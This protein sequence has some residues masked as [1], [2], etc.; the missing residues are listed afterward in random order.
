MAEKKDVKEW[1][2]MFYF[3]SDNPLAPEV[4]SQLKALKNAGYHQKVNVVAYFDPQSPGTPAH[5]FDVNAIDKRENSKPRIGFNPNDPFVRNL[6]LDKLWGED[7][8]G[9]DGT[10]I[11]DLIQ[12][13]ILKPGTANLPIA[14][15][16]PPPSAKRVA[17]AKPTTPSRTGKHADEAHADKG[18]KASL[19]EFLT[20][21]ASTYPAEHYML[22]ILGHGLVVG[23]DVFLFDEH[24]ARQSV[25]LRELGGVLTG[26]KK[27]IQ[28]HVAGAEFELV[29]FHSCSMSS[30]EVAY[31][32]KDTAKYMLASQ[33]PAFVSSW[34]YTQ[35]LIR[36]FN[37]VKKR[38]A[39]TEKQVE[40][41]VTKIFD[42]VL[43]NSTDFMLAGY[44]FDLSL[45]ELS[46]LTTIKE[47]LKDLSEALIKGLADKLV[48][49]CILLAHWK[50]QSYFNENYT[51]LYDFCFC[52][53]EY[54]DEFSKAVIDPSPYKRIQDACRKVTGV[55]QPSSDQP[56]NPVIHAEFAGPDSQH[57]H[58]FSIFFPWTRPTADRPIVKEYQAY[59][60]KE[61][62]WFGFI[63]K[64]W[65]DSESVAPVNG[66]MR[67][68]HEDEVM[69]ASE[70]EARLATHKPKVSKAGAIALAKRNLLEDIAS[71]MF[72]AEGPL[73]MSGAL[74]GDPPT[75]PNPQSSMGD[76]CACGSIKNYQRDTRER[77]DRSKDVKQTV[78]VSN[79]R[80]YGQRKL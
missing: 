71:L 61:T 19:E 1:T 14:S 67:L 69:L 39:T 60:F 59:K 13:F 75:K 73:S 51:D 79:P 40:V 11:R 37:D 47:P 70:A 16:T 2:L 10:T 77:L 22:F 38:R 30:L 49:N 53:S 32:L 21:C 25:T 63:D 78:P 68:S 33:G 55:L 72:N 6:M 7:Q 15:L 34:P 52:L 58:G 65:G 8:K 9:R 18:P 23:D 80:V 50:S 28:K 31:E 35:I 4:V 17:Q 62:N 44:S 48:T 45:C 76:G 41:M 56:N 20:F 36:V 57:S 74:S 46:K 64:Y 43:R 5:I 66:T 29:G 12:Q 26:F 27:D 54:C 24:A 3:A 42:Y